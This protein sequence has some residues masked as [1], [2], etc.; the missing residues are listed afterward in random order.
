MMVKKNMKNQ[1]KTRH[2]SKMLD[3][4]SSKFDTIRVN[5]YNTDYHLTSMTYLTPSTSAQPD[6]NLTLKQYQISPV[7]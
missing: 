2:F 3:C 5:K 7:A 4:W 6:I 1:L